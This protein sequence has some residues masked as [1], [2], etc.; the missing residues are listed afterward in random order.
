[1]TMPYVSLIK[2]LK[3]NLTFCYQDVAPYTVE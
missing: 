1:M 2:A 3:K